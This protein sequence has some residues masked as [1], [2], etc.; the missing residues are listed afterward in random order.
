MKYKK[1]TINLLVLTSLFIACEKTPDT[2]YKNHSY[3]PDNT[4]SA[5]PHKDEES[6]K[7]PEDASFELVSLELAREEAKEISG[8]E[9]EGFLLPENITITEK[10]TIS[11]FSSKEHYED[12]Y[13][14]SENCLKILWPEYDV[15]ISSGAEATYYKYDTQ[16]PDRITGV[17]YRLKSESGENV[18]ISTVAETGFIHHDGQITCSGMMI[19]KYDIEWG[20][21]YSEDEGFELS[22]GFVTIKDA[23]DF[24]ERRMNESLC[25]LFEGVDEFRV[26]HLYV[27]QNEDNGKYI[28][29]MIAGCVFNG[30]PLDTANIYYNSKQGSRNYN[31]AGRC[32]SFIMDKSDS[33][34]SVSTC[35]TTM[36][37]NEIDV[38]EKVISPKTALKIIKE[39]LALGG[40][41]GFEQAGLVGFFISKDAEYGEKLSQEELDR[42]GVVRPYWV[43]TNSRKEFP[44][45]CNGNYDSHENSVFVDAVTGEVF[46]CN[47]STIAPY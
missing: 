7:T 39:E 32:I 21:S 22:D 14:D 24:T 26:Q 33:F 4:V 27:F 15:F 6:V 38:I 18:E 29:K 34:D 19:K 5:T 47:T 31:F 2:N 13:K 46:F 25:N 42:M 37:F 17:T 16:N 8:Q 10:D 23:I 43:F 30:T 35:H 28:Y 11:V 9:I 45:S 1:A 36:D 41:G 3:N 12:D 40:I 20:D 44:A